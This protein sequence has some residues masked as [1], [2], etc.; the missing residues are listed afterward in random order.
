M[1]K[2]SK[3]KR[4][5][6][7]DPYEGRSGKNKR[8]ETREI[9]QKFKEKERAGKGAHYSL[10]EDIVDVI[11]EQLGVVFTEKERN[12]LQ[13]YARD[14]GKRDTRS[15][16][17][18]FFN[19]G[20]TETQLQSYEKEIKKAKYLNDP[21]NRPKLLAICSEYLR[22]KVS[23]NAPEVYGL[24]NGYKLP[25]IP[26]DPPSRDFE[27]FVF[28]HSD[29]KL[30]AFI[31]AKKIP[32]GEWETQVED[33]LKKIKTKKFIL[34]VDGEVLLGEVTIETCKE[35]DAIE[36]SARSGI[37]FCIYH[38]GTTEGKFIVERWD[39]E[40]LSVHRNK[41]GPD[42]QFDVNGY[43][44]VYT[45]HS[46]IHRYNVANRVP[47]G[48]N[49][50]PDIMPTPINQNRAPGQEELKY[51]D[52]GAMV[53]EFEKEFNLSLAQIPAHELSRQALKKLGKR[54]CP[55]YISAERREEPAPETLGLN[56][57]KGYDID[58]TGQLRI[59]TEELP[60]IPV[61][62]V[63]ADEQVDDRHTREPIAP[64]T[65]SNE[66]LEQTQAPKPTQDG[67]QVK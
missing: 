41:I 30:Y 32:V 54:Y 48:Q 15:Y 29:E 3:K 66:N 58:Y 7:F 63:Y 18:K 24:P 23:P 61:Y 6:I 12:I 25:D 21:A 59:K 39:Y 67:G 47:P 8:R 19:K 35:S 51:A 42:G 53:D 38:Q 1:G 14:I 34:Q 37:K 9:N 13:D 10:E 46:H 4:E 62:G 20:Y 50:S 33:R 65:Q 52:F 45:A 28:P 36:R 11:E 49:Q 60:T 56:L 26:N 31:K 5:R 17:L 22:R 44:P 27:H 16:S 2:K 64:T 43:E 57:P 40:P 55:N